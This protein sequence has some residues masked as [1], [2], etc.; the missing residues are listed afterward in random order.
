MTEILDVLE[1][2]D[3]EEM[4]LFKWNLIQGISN[5]KI[6]KSQLEKKPRH[7]VV[8][9]MTQRY[10]DDAR[11][12][13]MLILEKMKMM[14]LVKRLQEELGDNMETPQSKHTAEAAAAQK[15]ERCK[16]SAEF[17]EKHRAELIRRVSL[18]EPIADDMKDLIGDEKYGIILK[19]GTKHAQMRALLGFLTTSTLKEKCYQSLVKHE[20]FL[21]EDLEQSG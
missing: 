13:T 21:V 16:A 18:V 20:R 11:K 2:L 10:P 17:V 12:L 5:F 15:Q 4:D 6:P 3:S 8:D 1:E 9:C 14:N 19:S 7:A